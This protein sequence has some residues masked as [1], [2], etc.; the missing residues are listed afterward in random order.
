[1]MNFAAL[2][3][4]YK[5][6]KAG[7]LEAYPEL[8]EDPQALADTLEG[9]SDLKDVAARFICDALDDDAL[10]EALN[11][12]IDA[13]TERRRRLSERA[14]KRKA[15]A[16]SL[17]SG[18]DMPR[19]DHP[20]F[21]ASVRMSPPKVMVTDENAIPDAFVRI[22]RAPNKTALRDALERGED[23]PGAS[24]SNG[25]QTLQVRTR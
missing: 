13:M 16:L 18:V 9:I 2:S 21:T 25:S 14:A 12:R 1:M 5:R 20:E 10:A 11:A 19:L 4:D 17:M 7:L 3:E 15:I 23:I 6:Q 8:R 22:T 24:L